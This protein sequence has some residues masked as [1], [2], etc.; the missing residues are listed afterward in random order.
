M[1]TTQ[2]PSCDRLAASREKLRQALKMNPGDTS[3]AATV[4]HSVVA[5]LAQRNP[6][7]LVG[8][9][10]VIGCLVIWKRHWCLSV[11]STLVA[12]LLPKMVSIVVTQVQPM[13]WVE[14]LLLLIDKVL[15]SKQSSS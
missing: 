6:W 11:A 1:N 4:L 14:M 10:L 9:A 5:P 3:L 15:H 7:G 12:E 2:M 8:S 13:G